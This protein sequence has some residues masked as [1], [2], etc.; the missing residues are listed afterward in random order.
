VPKFPTL[1]SKVVYAE[2][3]VS[4]SCAHVILANFSGE[5]LT[6]PKATVLGVAEEMSE[7]LVNDKRSTNA[8]QK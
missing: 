1:E 4:G 6:V 8:C 5:E 2:T 3:D 7:S